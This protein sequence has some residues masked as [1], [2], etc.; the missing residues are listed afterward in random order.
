MLLL[1]SSF[2]SDDHLINKVKS[3]LG[4]CILFPALFVMCILKKLYV[5]SF[6]SSSW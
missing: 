6:T 2:P 5:I 4:A 3:W 1:K